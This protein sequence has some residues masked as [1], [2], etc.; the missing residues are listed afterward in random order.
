MGG[1]RD[2]PLGAEIDAEELGR[3]HLEDE[4]AEEVLRPLGLEPA[5]PAAPRLGIDEHGAAL[6]QH[7]RALLERLLAP[8]LGLRVLAAAQER[9]AAAEVEEAA[10]ERALHRAA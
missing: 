6:A 8:G 5:A 2:L 3:G 1:R 10:D 9:D 4:A 7:P